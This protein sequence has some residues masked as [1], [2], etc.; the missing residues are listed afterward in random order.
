MTDSRVAIGGCGEKVGMYW[1][2]K[3]MREKVHAG[4]G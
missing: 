3:W 4:Y 1:Q 2:Y